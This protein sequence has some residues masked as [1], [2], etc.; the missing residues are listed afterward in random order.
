MRMMTTKQWGAG[1]ALV[2]AGAVFAQTAEPKLAFDVAS[3]KPSPAGAGREG[4]GRMGM[5]MNGLLRGNIQVTPSSLTMRNA[6]LKNAIRWAYQVTEYQVS[7][8]DWLDSA[9]FD[10]AAKSAGAATEDQLR[11]M[12]QT[13][14][15]DRF[16]LEF[17]RVNKEFQVYALVPAKNGAKLQESKTEGEASVQPQQSTMSV[18]VQHMGLSQIIDMMTPI[19]GAPIIDKTGLKGKYDININLGKYV[20]EMQSAGSTAPPDP[21]ALIMSVLETE[22]G[23]K[24]EKQKI[25]LDVLVVDHADRS[26]TEN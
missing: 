10:I 23:L 14:L 9:R 2:T 1:L 4:G 15:A 11:L 13:L 8:P 12:L 25:P 5:G 18:A 6:T 3:V 19:M 16:K 21:V 24:L 7:G 20:A 26:P 22:A 17:H